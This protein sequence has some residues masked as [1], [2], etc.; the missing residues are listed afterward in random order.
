VCLERFLHAF[1]DYARNNVRQ[2]FFFFTLHAL[3]IED[4]RDNNQEDGNNGDGSGEMEQYEVERIAAILA[5][6]CMFL[7][8]L[9]IIFAVLLFLYFGNGGDEEATLDDEAAVQSKIVGSTTTSSLAQSMKMMHHHHQ[10][11]GTVVGTV[12]VGP[13]S[14][15]GGGVGGGGGVGDYD[16]L[17]GPNDP[18]RESFL[19]GRYALDNNEYINE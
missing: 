15:V 16:S 11:V 13:V 2:F 9:Y 18:R 12:G 14:V 1:C 7:S 5:V 17:G 6:T 10:G 19:V 3:Q 4:F 8:A